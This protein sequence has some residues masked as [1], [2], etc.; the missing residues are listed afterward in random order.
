MKKAI[1]SYIGFQLFFNL[2]LWVP[3]FYQVQKTLGL[4]DPQIFQIQSIYYLVFCL[5]E[6][7]TGFI[8]DRFGYKN[9]L[10]VGAGTLVL[11][12]VIPMWSG[13]FGGFLLHFCLIALSRSLISGASSAWLYEYLKA[14]GS[15]ELFKQTEGDARFYALVARIASWT[16]VGYLMQLGL[17]LPYWISA[18]NG[19]VAIFI[20]V[21]LPAVVIPV[22]VRKSIFSGLISAGRTVGKSPVL[23]LLILQGVG[24]FTLVRVLQVN[25]YQPVMVHKTFAITSFGTIMAV[26]TIFEAVGAKQAYRVRKMTSDVSAVLFS[27][28]VISC[29]LLFISLGNQAVTIAGLCIFSLAAGIAFPV[30]KQLLNDAIDN[31]GQRA[32]ILSMESFV[33]RAV[34]AVVVLPLGGLVA[35]GQLQNI[36]L[37]CG[38]GA[39]IAAITVQFMLKRVKQSAGQ[40]QQ[41][42][43]SDL[44]DNRSHA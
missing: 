22:S 16:V 6:I 12:N 21:S 41:I 5:L 25:L 23:F 38:G 17:M 34:C 44:Q 37:V 13:N 35:E 40:D 24:I 7:P 26:M 31:Q 18:A 10:I 42:L 30:Q 8:A 4:T 39:A 14:N 9:S 29:S 43:P 33:D 32:T 28:L 11:A 15:S 27:T 1:Y 36:L 19:L 2:L 20:A 3:V